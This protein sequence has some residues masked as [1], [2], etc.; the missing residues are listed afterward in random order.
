MSAS[1]TLHLCVSEP[2]SR[3]FVMSE[4]HGYFWSL[5]FQEQTAYN[6]GG[7][8]CVFH[9]IADMFHAAHMHLSTVSQAHS[10]Q[11]LLDAGYRRYQSHASW[12]VGLREVRRHL[13]TSHSPCE[14]TNHTLEKAA[15]ASPSFASATRMDSFSWWLRIAK[16]STR[17]AR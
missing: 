6:T 5:L 14:G 11:Q 12:M 16:S 8:L 4:A 2:C 15:R 1:T 10:Q 13:N 7:M 9:A 17:C 3:I